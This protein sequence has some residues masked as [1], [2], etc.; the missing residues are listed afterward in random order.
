M[1]E[2]IINAALIEAIRDYLKIK[3]GKFY[4][5]HIRTMPD[6]I[7]VTC[8]FHKDGQENKPSAT[9][10]I[11][12]NEKA[13]PGL[14]SCF[15]CH[16][17]MMIN[18]M[19][20]KILGPLYDA[21]EVEAKL[22]L[23]TLAVRSTFIKPEKE[24]IFNLDKETFVSRADIRRYE[25]YYH[26]YLKSRRI[27]EEVAKIYNIGFDKENN[28]IIFP[29]YNIEHKCVGLGRRSVDRKLYRYPQGLQ[30][31]LYGLYELDRFPHYVWVVEGPFN[32]WSLRGWGKQG[33]A[34]L[35]TGTEFQYKQL[36][37][38]DCKGFVLALDPDEAGINATNKLRN[39]L[40]K[41]KK[42]VHVAQIPYG[43]DINDLTHEEFRNVIVI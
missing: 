41:H 3:T 25:G 40:L 42:E 24:T 2:T 31:P 11:T 30:K 17:A 1:D 13:S 26:P 32:L 29:I 43:K 28:Q 38:I 14:F 7:Q 35:G 36:L 5:K 37:E 16:E 4:F 34:L 39:F 12:A 33:V 23:E 15:T 6:N 10:R 8:P 9:I 19:V 22:G 27:T 18:K 20:E 21:D